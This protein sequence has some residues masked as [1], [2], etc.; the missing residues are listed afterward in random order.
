MLLPNYVI[1]VFWVNIRMSHAMVGQVSN[2]EK[3]EVMHSYVFGPTFISPA[4]GLDIILL[5][6]MIES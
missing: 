3:L 6:S 1:F 4:C 2:V 5:S